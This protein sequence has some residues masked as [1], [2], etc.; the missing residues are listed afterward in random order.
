VGRVVADRDA[1]TELVRIVD[2]IK[3][4]IASK[5]AYGIAAD[6]SCEHLALNLIR[7]LR[8]CQE[9]PRETTGLMDEWKPGDLS[10]ERDHVNIRLPWQPFD[11]SQ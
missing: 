1:P 2:Q 5:T 7:A 6:E 4:M 10:E 9:V 11:F 3:P 8:L